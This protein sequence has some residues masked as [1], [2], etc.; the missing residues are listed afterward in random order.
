[1]KRA[2]PFLIAIL[3]LVLDQVTKIWVKTNL[4]IGDEFAVVSDWFYI[5]FTENNGMAFG[6]E[7]GG[8]TG[9]LLLSI[10][11]L[12]AIGFIGFYTFQLYKHRAYFAIQLAFALIFVGALGNIIDSVFYGVIFGYETW[13]YGRVVDMLYCP[14]WEGYMPQWVPIWGGDYCVFFRPVFNIADAAITIGVALLIVFQQ[15]F[16]VAMNAET[17]SNTTLN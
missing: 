4:H 8:R 17:A 9:K 16:F 10:F 1:M 5:H 11:R 3:V 13:F 12:I 15:R 14:V 7:F 6:L 2:A